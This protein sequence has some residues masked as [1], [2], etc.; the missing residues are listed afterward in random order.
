[1]RQVAWLLLLVALTVSR[2]G[3]TATKDS[4]PPDKEMLRMMDLLREMELIKQA[5]MIQDLSQV[6]QIGDPSSDN[7]VRQPLPGKRKQAAK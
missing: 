2:G 4:L 5:E 1:M 7:R 6:E 3:L